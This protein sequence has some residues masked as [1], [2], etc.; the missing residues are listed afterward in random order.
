M[1]TIH[2][3]EEVEVDRRSLGG[4]IRELR[5]EMTTL[6]RKEVHLARAETSEKVGCVARNAGYAV[7][8]GVVLF[9]GFLVLLWAAGAGLAVGLQAM[10]VA[11]AVA[12]WLGPL[13]VGAVAALIGYALLQKG[14]SAIRRT[15]VVPEK[16][17]ESIRRTGEWARDKMH[18]SECDGTE[19]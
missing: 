3:V 7:A 4:L 1:S 13:I 2:T 18:G 12:A 6:L 5:D 8:G 16:T 11:A 19:R 17:V 15:S 9:G 14:I 10:G